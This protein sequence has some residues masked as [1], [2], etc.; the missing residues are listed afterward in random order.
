MNRRGL[1]L[2]EIMVVV[3]IIAILLMIAVPQFARSKASAQT[4]TCLHNLSKIAEAKTIHAMKG[5]VEVGDAVDWVEVLAYL[6]AKPICPV[7][8]TY[9]VGAMGSN[10]TCTVP[11]HEL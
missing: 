8:G 2:I 1:T 7:G 9:E 3:G 5:G 10:P 11:G 6:K 4:K